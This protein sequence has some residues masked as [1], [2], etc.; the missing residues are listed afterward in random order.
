MAILTDELLDKLA[1]YFSSEH[2]RVVHSHLDEITF[3]QFLNRELRRIEQ[4]SFRQFAIEIVGES[5]GSFY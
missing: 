5:N 1:F 2:S 3:V 4:K